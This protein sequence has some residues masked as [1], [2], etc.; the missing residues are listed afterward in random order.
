MYCS[1]YHT[2][3]NLSKKLYVDSSTILMTM[4]IRIKANFPAER[5]REKDMISKGTDTDKNTKE[6]HARHQQPPTL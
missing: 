6:I 4:M 3:L 1:R 5:K 2:S